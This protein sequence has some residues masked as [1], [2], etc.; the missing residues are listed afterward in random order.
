MTANNNVLTTVEWP[1]LSIPWPD[2]P[3][4]T[5]LWCD[6]PTITQ[7]RV[8]TSLEK[9]LTASWPGGIL[10]LTPIVWNCIGIKNADAIVPKPKTPPQTMLH[11]PKNPHSQTQKPVSFQTLAFRLWHSDQRQWDITQTYYLPCCSLWSSN[12]SVS[13]SDSLCA[14][15]VTVLAS[16]QSSC[17]V[18]SPSI[19]SS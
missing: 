13:D 5:L 9:A 1:L 11:H 19:L 17:A 2:N 18:V 14:P 4:K 3:K 15:S 8:K 10:T 16:V 7:R 12:V 6:A